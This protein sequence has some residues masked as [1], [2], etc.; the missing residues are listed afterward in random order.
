MGNA[1]ESLVMRD[2]RA[3]ADA[4]GAEVRYYAE[5]SF[6]VD[7][8]VEDRDGSWIA[9]EIKLS[10]SEQT[11]RKAS[12]ALK[13]L[14]SRARQAGKRPPAKLVAVFGANAPGEH[15]GLRIAREE[16]G[17]AVVPFATLGP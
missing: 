3:Y 9:V 1:F 15:T 4:N 5:S 14:A 11:L 6:E 12:Q 16:D 17:I 13:L 7:A 10:R 2:L 8:V